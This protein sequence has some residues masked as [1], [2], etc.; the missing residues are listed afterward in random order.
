MFRDDRNKTE[1]CLPSMPM[2]AVRILELAQRRVC[3]ITEL[4]QV[5]YQDPASVLALLR[6]ARLRR[7]RCAREG[8]YAAIERLGMPKAL[9]VCLEFRL[10]ES[11]ASTTVDYIRY[12]R[13][14]LLTAAYARAIA[15]RLRS[16]ETEHI[17]VAALLRN[18]GDLLGGDSAEWLAGQ[19]LAANLCH[20]IRRSHEQAL[21][22]G[23]GH[24]AA[25]CLALAAGM[26]EVW[27]RAD[28][29]TGMA[30]TQALAQRLF[31]TIPD[32]CSWVFG[33]LG[34][35]A[36]DLEALALIRLPSRRDS[37]ELYRRAAALRY[38]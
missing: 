6:A 15:T 30:Q 27:L 32:L 3:G 4:W 9:H 22:V 13:R 18:V 10:P 14:A 8:L 16:R 5:V 31:G 33:V 19:G 38:A 28:W 29:E 21:D 7:M 37:E 23:A 11:R 35:Q 17:H 2:T 24:D 26:A 25:A 1:R 20:W 34:P 12:W 36:N